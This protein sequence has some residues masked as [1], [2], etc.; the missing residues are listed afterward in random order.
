MYAGGGPLFDESTGETQDRYD[1]LLKKF[2]DEPWNEPIGSSKLPDIDKWLAAA[3]LN[4]YGDPLDTMYAG[5]NPLFDE[6]T[7]ETQDR[8]EYL[9]NKFPDQPW[10]DVTTEGDGPR[11]GK[12]QAWQMGKVDAWLASQLYNE[13]GDP[14]GTMYAGGAPLFDES[15]GE[16]QDRYEYL[17]EKF[18]DEPWN[19]ASVD[20][21]SEANEGFGVTIT[22][23][24]ESGDGEET[25][26]QT[27]PDD[28]E[29][30]TNGDGDGDTGPDDNDNNMTNSNN[31]ANGEGMDMTSG[32]IARQL[33]ISSLA[34]SLALIL[35][36]N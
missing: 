11:D 1:Y 8:Y 26:E 16:T 32:S 30:S 31:P 20:E 33:S 21:G 25:R 13:Y 17:K 5:G 7:G 6:S 9:M 12:A 36:A 27:D 23:T 2:P 29:M 22:T 4:Q 10:N 28:N 18:P 3:N 19:D 14:E 15:T 34:L 24:E 35:L